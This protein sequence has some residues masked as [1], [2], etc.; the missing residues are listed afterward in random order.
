LVLILLAHPVDAAVESATGSMASRASDSNGSY[1][2][3]VGVSR[4]ENPGQSAEQLPVSKPF[5]LGFGMGLEARRWLTQTPSE[6]VPGSGDGTARSWGTPSAIYTDRV[7]A[8]AQG[9]SQPAEASEPFSG[10]GLALLYTPSSFG[11]VAPVPNGSSGDHYS[12]IPEP[13][14]WSAISLLLL[15][16]VWARQRR[17]CQFKAWL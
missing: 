12:A 10:Q 14:A 1:N 3:M 6:S 17:G 5:R 16:A 11:G 9:V 4:S 15:A 8:A 7:T 2:D 13:R